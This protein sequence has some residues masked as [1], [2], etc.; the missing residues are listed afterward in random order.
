MDPPLN[1]AEYIIQIV[2]HHLFVRLA[3]STASELMGMRSDDG[4]PSVRTAVAALDGTGSGEQVLHGIELLTASDFGSE[5]TPE[6]LDWVEPRTVGGSGP[7][8]AP[9]Q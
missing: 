8:V 5:Q 7:V 6:H 2:R 9:K 4:A 1:S 3:L